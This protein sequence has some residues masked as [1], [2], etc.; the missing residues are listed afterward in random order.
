MYDVKYYLMKLFAQTCIKRNDILMILI[1]PLVINAVSKGT[2][3]KDLT[4]AYKTSLPDPLNL[5]PLTLKK[6]TW[7]DL[8]AKQQ[9]NR[10]RCGHI[11]NL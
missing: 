1:L 9:R 7:F 10:E 6:L 11:P 3:Q 4:E 2:G 8:G 5:L